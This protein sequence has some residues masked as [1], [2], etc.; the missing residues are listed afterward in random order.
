MLLPQYFEDLSKNLNDESERIKKFFKTHAVTAGSNREDL[1][2]KFL[3]ESLPKKFEISSGLV[4]SKDGQFSKQA[5]VLVADRLNNAPLFPLAAEPIWFAEA[6]YALIEVKTQ[7]TPT[8]L[9]D[10][11]EKCRRFKLLKREYDG[12]TAQRIK[13]S[14]F[15]LWSFESPSPETAKVNI[16]NVLKGVPTSERPD[17]IVVPGKILCIS[18]H[19]MEISKLGQ[20]G[21]ELRNSLSQKH[22]ADL[23]PLLG[24]G[25]EL[26]DFGNNTL[27][28]FT[29]WFGSWLQ[30]AGGRSAPLQKYLPENHTFGRWV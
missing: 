10:S 20:E 19:F 9:S 18:G 25:I 26:G 14:I 15:A 16:L 5:D 7:L 11:I 6:I 2:A 30:A 22:G 1:V 28:A 12:H 23:N 4:M 17:F 8:T 21:S 3:T 24:E 27:L 29:I 13:E